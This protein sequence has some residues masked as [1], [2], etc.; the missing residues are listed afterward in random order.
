MSAREERNSIT[1]QWEH[2]QMFYARLLLTMMISLSVLLVISILLILRRVHLHRPNITH[3]SETAS[4]KP[5]R[6][7]LC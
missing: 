3:V 2:E 6:K 7:I 1:K 5:K 4:F